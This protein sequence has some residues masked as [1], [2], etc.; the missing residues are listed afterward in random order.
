MSKKDF[1]AAFRRVVGTSC[2]QT[3]EA[4]T[5]HVELHSRRRAST[6]EREKKYLLAIRMSNVFPHRR[7]TEA[8]HKAHGINLHFNFKLGSFEKVLHKLMK[9]GHKDAEDLDTEPEKYPRNL[10]LP[11]VLG[12]DPAPVPAP[13]AP[14]EPE[15]EQW[16]S[17][18]GDSTDAEEEAPADQSLRGHSAL[19]TAACPRQY[20]REVEARRAQGRMIPEDFTKE[21]FLTKLRR[22]IAKHCTAK[23]DKATCHSEPHKRFRPSKQRRE[24]HYH[25]ALKMSGN[26][27]HKKIADAFQKEHGIRVSFS[28]KLNRFVGNLLYLTEAGNFDVK[29]WRVSVRE[30]GSIF[31]LVPSLLRGVPTF[32]Q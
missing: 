26:F 18:E 3:L 17:N 24:R 12:A 31:L 2:N 10:E 13:L 27:A 32:H 4:A 21:E 9:P 29:L 11:F 28:F 14:P 23:V 22:T 7:L 16:T 20:P 19:V 6:K 30:L 1:L 8:F 15:E 5:C 25:V